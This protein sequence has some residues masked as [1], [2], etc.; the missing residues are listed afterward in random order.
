[1]PYLLRSAWLAVFAALVAAPPAAKADDAGVAAFD[2]DH[3]FAFNAG[4]DFDEPGSKEIAAALTGRF[5]RSGG[6]YRA[7][8]GEVSLQ[9]TAARNLQLELA[10][11]G[12]YY[13]IRGVPDMDNLDRAAFGGL[14]LGVSYR[15]L[16]RATHGFG[17]A[18]SSAP[19]WT[20]VDDDSGE[21]VNGYG[22]DFVLAA[23]AEL[24]PKVLVGVLNFIYEPEQTKSRVDGSWSRENTAGIGG[25]LMFKLKDNIAVGLEARYL[26]KYDSLD[27]GAFAGQAFYLGPTLSV[28]FSDDAWLTVGWSAQIAGR[29]AGED[30][31]LDLVNF[32]R[33]QARLA[34]GVKF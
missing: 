23:D 8:E 10:A 17:L 19:Y 20:R 14:S 30:G 34:F 11:R 2:T 27:F 26:R 29:P 13:R 5:G 24:V 33:N 31:A 15:L 7:D 32:E 22:S 3:L 1:M 21:R 9:Y 25:G 6:T 18:V 28:S 4:S 16:D 12:T